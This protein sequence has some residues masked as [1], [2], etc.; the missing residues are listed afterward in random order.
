MKPDRRF[1]RSYDR[2][3]SSRD[4]WPF[5]RED[6]DDILLK[7][8][9]ETVK[10][11]EKKP[12]PKEEPKSDKE[13]SKSQK[14]ESEK[15]PEEE[16]KDKRAEIVE[17]SQALKKQYEDEPAPNDSTT[18][19]RLIVA[20]RIVS[21]DKQLQHPDK[22]AVRTPEEIEETLDYMCLLAEKL[23]EPEAESLPEIEEIYHELIELTDAALE[24][25][26]DPNELVLD[27]DEQ[28]QA[29]NET[30]SPNE[31]ALS[32]EP[33]SRQKEAPKDLTK[34][35]KAA[36]IV[37]IFT[38]I[39]RPLSKR[40]TAV[41]EPPDPPTPDAPQAYAS[42][43]PENIYTAPTHQH[44][45]MPGGE[46]APPPSSPHEHRSAG[47]DTLSRPSAHSASE[48]HVT[49]SGRD[50]IHPLASLAVAS[51][52]ATKLHKGP[53]TSAVHSRLEVS[54]PATPAYNPEQYVD[55]PPVSA[56]H[57]TPAP[58]TEE[59]AP[60]ISYAEQ[61]PAPIAAP[62]RVNTEKH[63]ESPLK[64]LDIVHRE[65]DRKLE[66]M[67]LQSLLTLAHGVHLGYGQYLKDEFEKGTIDKDGL[68]K[69]L[70]ARAKGKDFTYEFREQASHFR[71]LKSSPEFLREDRI[72]MSLP[73]VTPHGSTSQD[74][75]PTTLQMPRPVNEES[76]NQQQPTLP[77]S[78]NPSGA[79]TDTPSG[80][81]SM[82]KTSAKNADANSLWIIAIIIGALVL[83]ALLWTL[84]S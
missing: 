5:S 37:A 22:D 83:G 32:S 36:A 53:E 15:K 76:D 21:L 16:K 69:V 17:R 78:D 62:L 1:E 63:H 44:E 72:R 45:E 3:E 66:H 55:M 34:S 25:G 81:D 4:R 67:S 29:I 57:D 26:D 9:K 65:A 74:T 61:A 42:G 51:V 48:Y 13:T 49:T 31:P 82:A 47:I 35:L 59:Q 80:N 75:E 24:Q 12:N 79:T 39:I 23:E 71:L 70:K 10:E 2:D 41:A 27:I 33:Q 56:K 73:S 38:R 60:L 54:A 52:I 50:H 46:Y 14:A 68:I 20:E 19:T 30:A 6:E 58:P 84:F 11:T 40:S 64:P 18:L 7:R 77:I 28:I 8:K 43:R